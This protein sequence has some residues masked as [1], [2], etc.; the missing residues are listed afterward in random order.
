[1]K[2]NFLL[3][4]STSLY[5]YEKVRNLPIYDYHCHL[6]PQEIYEDKEFDNIGEM[7]MKFDHYKWRLMRSCD[8]PEEYVTGNASFYE[9]FKAYAKAVSM[10]PGNPL[11]HWSHMELSMYFG[12]DDILNEE[13]ADDIWN[14]ANAYIKEKHLSPRKLMERSKVK[15]VCT[16][17]DICDDLSF[18]KLIKEDET[19]SCTVLPT[20]R[21]DKLLFFKNADYF[22]YLKKL[23]D[24]T[25]I[26]IDSL[27]ALKKA[28]T[29]RLEYFKTLGCVYSDIGIEGFPSLFY[30][31]EK[32]NDIFSSV[33]ARENV[34][35]ESLN[36]LGGNIVVFLSKL[37]KEYDIISQIHFAVRR[38]SNHALFKK[39]GPDIGV[40]IM[41]DSVSTRPLYDLFNA[42]EDN[43]KT[44]VYVLDPKLLPAT[45]LLCGSFRNVKPG[46]AWW[47]CDTKSG[48]RKTLE[49]IAELSS[50]GSF[51]G[52]LTDSR[53]FLSYARHD[54]YRRILCSLFG[55]WLESGEYNDEK[56]A[57]VLLKRLCTFE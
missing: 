7:W 44:I 42:V 46:A 14:R 51:H 56:N 35:D 3:N 21:T 38:N 55:E 13:N 12:I 32:A 54:Y 15:L 23:S 30:N 10:S 28:V 19:I 49:T 5:L 24:I 1:M 4:N 31:D 53:S 9:K 6:L 34:S 29:Q 17:D 57:I 18:H 52:M 47:F 20:F 11:Y 39:T 48:I 27:S 2:Y 8:I 22:D 45:V 37:Y 40:D 26:K 25:G 36:G 16:T 43:P 33:L 50:L 41:D